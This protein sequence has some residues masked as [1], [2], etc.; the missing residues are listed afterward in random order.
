MIFI[1]IPAIAKDKKLIQEE[2]SKKI[3]LKQITDLYGKVIHNLFGKRKPRISVMPSF[4][5]EDS[6]GPFLLASLK[7]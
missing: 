3:F 4:Q 2:I 7:Y 5:F 1:S 6:L